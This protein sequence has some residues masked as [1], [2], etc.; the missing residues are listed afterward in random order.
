MPQ[1]VHF[2]ET[3]Q[4]TPCHWNWIT[5]SASKISHTLGI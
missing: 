3:V 4:D 2:D 5:S 1:R